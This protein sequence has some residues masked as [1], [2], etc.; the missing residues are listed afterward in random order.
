M[1]IFN[2]P[3]ACFVRKYKLIRR[4]VFVTGLIVGTYFAGVGLGW[5]SNLF[6]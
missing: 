4:T 1:P 5:W 6:G 3:I 2:G